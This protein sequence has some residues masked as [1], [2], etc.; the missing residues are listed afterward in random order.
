MDVRP[1][2]AGFEDL[3]HGTDT[4]SLVNG[5]IDIAH[6]EMMMMMNADGL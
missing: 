1:G 6:C 2:T 3:A 5:T 4:D